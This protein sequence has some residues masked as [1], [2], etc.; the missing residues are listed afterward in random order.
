MALLFTDG[1]KR[2]FS[3]IC[4]AAGSL[5]K[6]LEGLIN[7]AAKAVFF[8]NL[9]H[10]LGS[11]AIA[12]LEWTSIA[13]YTHMDGTFQTQGGMALMQTDNHS[14]KGSVLTSAN[15]QPRCA[16]ITSIGYLDPRMAKEKIIRTI[17]R[18]DAAEPV[19][20]DLIEFIRTQAKNMMAA[21]TPVAPPSTPRLE[22]SEEPAPVADD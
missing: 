17:D 8:G 22:Q 13:I 11:I 16:Y 15:V 2:L 9:L 18:V 5:L 14:I 3:Q 4:P 7:L 10:R 20:K 19:A 6:I 21:G 1:I 12:E